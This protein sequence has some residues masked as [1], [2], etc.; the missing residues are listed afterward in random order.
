[1]PSPFDDVREEELRRRRT[2]K[3]TLYGPEVLAAWVAETDFALAP[4]V[5]AALVEAVDRSDLGY[6]PADTTELTTACADFLAQ[7]YGWMVPP[8]RIFLVAD[9]LAGITGALEA[10]LPPG[11]GVVVPTPAYPP[12]FE[13]IGLTGRTV[14]EVPL[15]DDAGRPTLDL[16][17]IGAVL[18]SGARAVLLCSPQNPTGRV[19]T[20]AELRELASIVDRHGGR[21]IA[22][23]VHAPLVYPGSRFVPYATVSEAA[24]DHTV[25]VTSASKAWNIPALRCAQVI[26]SNH[27]DAATWRALPLYRVPDA[28]SLG[29]VAS[30]AAYLHGRPWLAELVGY[31]DGNRR[32]LGELVAL[33]VPGVR[34]REP[35]GTYLAWLD[36]AELGVADPAGFFLHEAKVAVNDGPSFGAGWDRHVRL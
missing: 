5:R 28:T 21:V 19:F 31:L 11:C 27:A 3:W 10:F 1:M 2:V 33:E 4:P 6:A 26:A 9:V 29:I 15:A 16:E 8:A 18:S 17:A 22:D 32:L 7:S 12:F 35:E 24:A 30:T 25:T 13:I 23:E 34:Y 20:L 14:V 36:C